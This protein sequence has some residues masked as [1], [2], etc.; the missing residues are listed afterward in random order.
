MGQQ[1]TWTGI[2]VRKQVIVRFPQV[3]TTVWSE[4]QTTE[5]EIPSITSATECF[6]YSPGA[7][8]HFKLFFYTDVFDFFLAKTENPLYFL[9]WLLNSKD[10]CCRQR[11][12]P[13]KAKAGNKF[14]G[15]CWDSQNFLH[16][17]GNLCLHLQPPSSSPVSVG[18]GIIDITPCQL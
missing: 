11:P 9:V 4:K 8:S 6:Y 16:L 2:F 13:Y 7:L 12:Q 15:C 18:G 14:S 3:S 10:L 5:L 1:S 17:A